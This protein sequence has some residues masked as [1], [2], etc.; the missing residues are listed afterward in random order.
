MTML[1][2]V[3]SAS[4][5]PFT[6]RRIL[7]VAAKLRCTVN[8]WAAAIIASYERRAAIATLRQLDD[9]ELK[10]IGLYRGQIDEAIERAAR[11][12]LHRLG[13]F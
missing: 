6:R 12:R 5:M 8:A 3:S 1:S 11:S 10:D 9:R 2:I 13:R 4:G 7:F